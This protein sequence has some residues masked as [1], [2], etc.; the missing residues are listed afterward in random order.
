MMLEQETTSGSGTRVEPPSHLSGADYTSPEVWEEERE[1]IRFGDRPA[2]ARGEVAEP[3]DYLV[4][5]LAGSRSR[6]R[7]T[8]RASSTASTTSAAPGTK[9]VDDVPAAGH[10]RKA[11]VCPYHCGPTT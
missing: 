6:S 10:V 7:G 2:R 8:L 11:F 5:D 9:F 3:G 1:R 4:R